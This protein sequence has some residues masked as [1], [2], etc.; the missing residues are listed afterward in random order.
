[1]NKRE[2]QYI[3]KFNAKWNNEWEYISGYEKYNSIITIRHTGCGTV[4]TI[5]ADNAI[6]K[7]INHITCDTCK[8][9]SLLAD[10]FNNKYEG[11][12][13]YIKR[14]YQDNDIKKDIHIIECLECGLQLERKGISL[15]NYI[16][17]NKKLK[18]NHMTEEEYKQKKEA[19]EIE[20]ELKQ[21]HKEIRQIEIRNEQF[22]KDLRSIKE[23]KICG[24][25]FKSTYNNECC[26][27]T[28]KKKY[29]NRQKDL[30]K[31][32]K[33]KTIIDNDIS[34]EKLIQRD[35]G[36]CQLCGRPIDESDYYIDD[37]GYFI[38]G[39]DYPSIDHTYP[40]AK[41]GTH[42]WDNVQLAHFKC[43]TDKNDK[44]DYEVS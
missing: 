9:S 43:N 25:I 23:C 34:L 33:N 35:K 18:C 10:R 17:D 1:M 21:I 24:T 40:L 29:K 3:Y 41:G 13:K 30:T 38:T 36:I 16:L 5:Q 20:R 22:E 39:N 6:R 27:D 32:I 7:S 8:E 19:E 42:T 44:L 11:K 14:L 2:E 37:N 15:Y 26:S 12:F 31:R 28:C 4:R